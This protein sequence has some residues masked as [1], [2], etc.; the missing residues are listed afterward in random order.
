MVNELPATTKGED[1]EASILRMID[2]TDPEN[3]RVGFQNPSH[4][5]KVLEYVRV[6]RQVDRVSAFTRRNDVQALLTLSDDGG[7]V[8]ALHRA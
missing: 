7:H 5:A 8:S 4:K 6:R 3:G 2:G 1:V